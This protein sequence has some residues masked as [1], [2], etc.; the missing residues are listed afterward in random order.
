MQALLLNSV[1]AAG[2]GTDAFQTEVPA[3][4][5]PGETVISR[6]IKALLALGIEDIVITTGPF[7]DA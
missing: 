4:I 5:A 6:Q 2:W 3:G 7:A 1:L